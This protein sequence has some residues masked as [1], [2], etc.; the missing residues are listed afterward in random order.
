MN[1]IRCCRCR[2]DKPRSEFHKASSRRGGRSNRCKP[3]AIEV[4]S[5]WYKNNK[6]RKRAYDAKRRE[7]KRHLYRA[8]SKRWRE[9]NKESKNADTNVRRKRVRKNMPPWIRPRD[10]KCIYDQAS[11]VSQC[12]GVQ[13]HVD[14]IHP[15]RGRGLRGL[16]VPWN[17][18]VLPA[19]KN[20]E[21]SNK[22]A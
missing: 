19:K 6:D 15:L 21:K 20:L 16:H 17:L 10:M 2:Q 11:R 9:A 12:L 3:C 8:A 7:E 1:T 13:H 18:Q 5:E 14:H 4:A 22:I